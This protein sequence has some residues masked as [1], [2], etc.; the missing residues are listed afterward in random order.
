MTLSLVATSGLALVALHAWL[1]WQR[2]AAGNWSPAVAARWTV[3]ALLCA[4]IVALRRAGV[5][6]F[7]GKK[8]LVLWLLVLVLHATSGAPAPE[9]DFTWTLPAAAAGVLCSLLLVLGSGHAPIDALVR[10]RHVVFASA[11]A[12]RRLHALRVDG[13]RPPPLALAR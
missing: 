6:L 10:H 9:A 1:L 11:P 8:A 7:W 13:P 12:H 3:A 2:V 5:P 4:G